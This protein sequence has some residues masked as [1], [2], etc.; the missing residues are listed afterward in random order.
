MNGP[1]RPTILGT[2][3]FAYTLRRAQFRLADL[4][5]ADGEYIA[6]FFDPKAGPTGAKTVRV[7]SGT[8]N[9]RTLDFVDDYVM[10]II[11]GADKGQPARSAEGDERNEFIMDFSS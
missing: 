10:H 6:R 2:G 11:C 7:Q 1:A 4:P 5:L 8:V 9:F 3:G